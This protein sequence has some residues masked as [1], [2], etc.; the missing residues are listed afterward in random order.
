MWKLSTAFNHAG[1]VARDGSGEDRPCGLFFGY[2]S[3][4]TVD[5]PRVCQID[6]QLSGGLR[7]R[8]H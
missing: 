4:L 1:I 7:R 8:S 3:S 5:D 2:D 6:V